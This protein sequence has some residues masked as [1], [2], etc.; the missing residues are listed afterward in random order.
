MEID[1]NLII[2]NVLQAVLVVAI[3]PIV[4]AVYKY[5]RA[6]AEKL[7]AE[8]R[9]WSPSTMD[10]VERVAKFAV[11]AAEQAGVAELIDD[12][13]KYAMSVAEKWLAENG[14]V[15]DLDLVDAAIEKAVGELNNPELG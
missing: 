15:V 8:A 4:V 2:S 7:L 14:L 12:K 5:I 9:E 1:W 11:D 6:V 13:K 10:I 3:P